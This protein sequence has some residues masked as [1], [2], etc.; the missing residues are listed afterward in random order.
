MKNTF[1]RSFA[2]QRSPNDESMT[3]AQMT[4]VATLEALT[5]L[6]KPLPSRGRLG[7]SDFV[8][9]STF[10]IGHSSFHLVHPSAAPLRRVVSR[11]AAA[12]ARL[13]RGK[14]GQRRPPSA[15]LQTKLRFV[16]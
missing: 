4:N 16:P 3:N 13:R 8:I 9:D 2:A 12:T 14:P 5:A 10:V 6:V 11:L 15:D 7:H 1:E